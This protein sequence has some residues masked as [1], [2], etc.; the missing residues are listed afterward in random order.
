M[1]DKELVTAMIR[2][3]INNMFHYYGIEGTED[4]INRCTDGEM[5]TQMLSIYNDIVR[6]GL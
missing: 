4:C 3:S 2:D 6:R 1:E 5:R